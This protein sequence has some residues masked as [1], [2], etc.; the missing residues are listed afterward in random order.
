M[1]SELSAGLPALASVCAY[2][3]FYAFTEPPFGLTPNTRFVFWGGSLSVALEQIMRA[4]RAREGVIAVTGDTGTGKTM[5]CRALASHL[6]SYTLLSM[7]VNPTLGADDLL[8]QILG[9]FGV[10]AG[11][12]ETNHELFRLLE[13]FL[14]A[15]S[16]QGDRAVIIIDE[17]QHLKPEV[18]EQLRLLSNLESED[19]KLLQ[20]VLVGHPDL[21]VL[22]QRP[23][24]RGFEQRVSRRCELEPLSPDD[25]RR[26]VGHRLAVAQTMSANTLADPAPVP[27][28]LVSGDASGGATR[29]VEFTPAALEAIATLSQGVPR[30]V[31]LLCDR[32]LEVAYGRELRSIDVD[33]VKT[34]A[35]KLRLRARAV[36]RFTTAQTAVLAAAAVIVMIVGVSSWLLTGRAR[37]A[38]S[39][40]PVASSQPIATPPASAPAAAAAPLLVPSPVGIPAAAPA[41]QREVVRGVLLAVASFRT[42]DRAA[43]LVKRIEHRGLQAFARPDASGNWQQVVVGPYASIQ[44]AKAAKRR[45]AGLRIWGA[46]IVLTGTTFDPPSRGAE[47]ERIARTPPAAVVEQKRAGTPSRPVAADTP[48]D[49][50]SAPTA[51]A[52]NS[53][54]L[55]RERQLTRKAE[56]DT[57]HNAVAPALAEFEQLKPL[58]STV[59]GARGSEPRP[60]L[61]QHLQTLVR[62]EGD[63]R[64]VN[65]PSDLARTHETLRVAIALAAELLR[66]PGV[67]ARDDAAEVTTLIDRVRAELEVV[68]PP[69]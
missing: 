13:D 52:L 4:L 38:P 60:D 36:S 26:Y 23:E 57:Y 68:R 7:I 56:L 59:T 28:V 12:R 34:A 22:L 48:S 33:L 67:N 32:T 5:L 29:N 21:D 25:V 62:V 43:D 39:S 64:K 16:V 61:D 11:S 63:L 51:P 6:K 53:G 58:L 42:A 41:D 44:E 8:R 40:A 18:F 45:L 27:A 30:V 3:E 20:I 65:V 2:D 17:A 50:V 49:S 37:P 9:D 1:T 46:S 54:E 24:Q 69:D 10:M 55:D 47:P 14:V 66:R 31:N 35:A 19:A 15:R